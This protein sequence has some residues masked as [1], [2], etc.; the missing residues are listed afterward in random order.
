M[1]T[2]GEVWI[3]VE[4]RDGK[5]ARVTWELLSAGREAAGNLGGPLT[6]VALG[7]QLDGM[8][9]ELFARGA[10]R[11]LQLEHADLAGAGD[12]A[13][14]ELLGRVV[15]EHQPAA[16][17]LAGTSTGK[18]LAPRLAAI[19]G[20]GLLADVTDLT[21]NDGVIHGTHPTLGSRGRASCRVEGTPQLVTLRPKAWPEAGAEPGR[22]GELLKPEVAADSLAGGTRVKEF[23]AKVTERVSLEE[24]DIIVSGGRGTG[25][26]FSLIEQLAD[27]VGGA[28]GA[29]RAAVD[30]GWIPYAHQVGQTGKTVAPKIYIACGISGAIQHLAGMQSAGTIIAINKNPDAPIFQIA[31]FGIVGDLAEVL[32]PL[33]EEFRK[34]LA[35]AG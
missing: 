10:D 3:V 1:S 15:R 31:S 7:H 33:I 20:A 23:I 11:V 4:H 19:L 12:Q 26:D 14:A 29:S 16:V 35:Q 32:P 5:P 2:A 9:G 13:R 18:S 24:A 27:A 8:A 30:A 6:A 28:V 22:Q 21:V 17:F 25:G 34:E